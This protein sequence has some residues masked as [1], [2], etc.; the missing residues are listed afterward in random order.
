MRPPKTVSGCACVHRIESAGKTT[1]V[2]PE[3]V[4]VPPPE[5]RVVVPVTVNVPAPDVTS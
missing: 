1:F 5:H 4:P 3:S 2:V